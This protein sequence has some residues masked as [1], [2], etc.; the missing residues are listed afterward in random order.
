MD[1]EAKHLR[2]IERL[3]P[4]REIS[5]R[6]VL[7]KKLHKHMDVACSPN[8]ECGMC[9]CKAELHCFL[10]AAEIMLYRGDKEGIRVGREALTADIA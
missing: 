7:L 6:S 10:R 8:R 1:A 9:M 4:R 2:I 5:M 3:S